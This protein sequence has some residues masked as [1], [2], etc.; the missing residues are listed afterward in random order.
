MPRD[1]SKKR[2][3]H[4]SDHEN[5]LQEILFG[6]TMISSPV[7]HPKEEND[8]INAWVDEDDQHIE[9]HLDQT[10]RTRKLRK[11]HMNN[12]I[13]SGDTFT[14]LLKERF[15]TRELAWATSG[16]SDADAQEDSEMAGLLATS[17]SMLADDKAKALP[18]GRLDIKRLVDANAAG[19]SAK[20]I[21]AVRFHPN[22][23]MLLA[24]G[25][26]KYL[27]FFRVDGEK[28]EMRLS[29]R[30]ND[31]A[32][33]NAQFVGG[34]T[35]GEV[36]IGGRKPYFYSYDTGSGAVTKIP[37]CMGKN[38]KSHEV[39]AVSPHDGDGGWLA[40]AGQA[41]YVHLL[42]SREKTWVGD[43]K[44]SRGGGVRALSFLDP[45]VLCASGGGA[46]VYL[47]DLRMM[48]N[49]GGSRLL[50]RFSHDDGTYTS[51]L[52]CTPTTNPRA[53]KYAAV[54]AE[55]GVVSVYDMAGAVQDPTTHS[56]SGPSK[57]KSVMNLTM[58]ITSL[59]I[60]PSGELMAMASDHKKDHMKMVHLPSCSVFSN[61]PT[62]RTPL[63]RVKCLD[64][65]PGGAYLAQGDHRG[66]VM[67]YRLNHY[68]EA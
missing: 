55:S 57:L 25:E 18:S 23:S 38:I 63:G 15:Q 48:G 56:V 34:S 27:R 21:N 42:S 14:S 51:S 67:L 40:V 9:V 29:V 19:P 10:A 24:A 43:V 54:G 5:K 11:Q 53:H 45:N 1:L 65:S 47:W 13:V 32:I 50:H 36:V 64:F 39:L 12:D 59:A 58:K 22:G 52:A 20:E 62:E 26:D 2:R 46:E 37:G 41:G 17:G 61:W 30:F 35:S 4:D 8:V 33:K 68:S 49:G 31:M 6:K 66:K 7:I 28:N 3:R 16:A 60:H 44:I